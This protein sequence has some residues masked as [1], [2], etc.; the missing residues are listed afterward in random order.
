MQADQ[1][2]ALDQAMLGVHADLAAMFAI[3][4][5]ADEDRFGSLTGQ[6]ARVLE[7]LEPGPADQ[8]EVAVYLATLIRWL[9]TDPWPQDARFSGQPLTP[10]RIERKLRIA[11]SSNR[12]IDDRDADDLGSRCVRLVV[13]GGPGSGKTWL[14]RRTARLCA[15]AALEAL[16]GGAG[17]EEVE[18]PLYT[19]CARLAAA[20]PGDNI[21]SAVVSTALG[22]LPDLGGSRVSDALRKLFEERHAATLLVADSLD[23]AHGA[24]DRIRQADS[25]PAVWRI[26]LTSRPASWNR[27]LN[28]PDDDQA[29]LVGV[30]QP[31]RY[32]VDVEPFITSWF[33]GQPAS[34]AVLADQLRNRPGLQQAATVPLVLTFYC[35]IGGDAPL[36]DRRADLYAKV[37]RRM[38]TGRWRGGG[39][40]DPN[41]EA[42]L[43]VLRD[44]AW[45][46]AA[47]NR[48]S[49]VGAWEDEFP[50]RRPRVSQDDRDA[51]GHVAAP[52]GPADADTGRTWRRFVHRSV[53]E[54]LVAEDVAALPVDKAA[55]ALLPHLWY[56]PDWEYSA[57]AAI[58]MHPEHDQLLRNLICLA[59]RSDKMPAD[60]SVIDSGREFRS[61]LARVAA[62]SSEAD[63]APEIAGV[64]AGARLGLARS[65]WTNDLSAA[66]HWET[67][68]RPIRET[69]LGLLTNA[70]GEKAAHLADNILQLDPTLE[71][72]TR[73]RTA[74]MQMMASPIHE[75]VAARLVP[76]V[77]RLAVTA[78]EKRQASIALLELL[79]TIAY[80]GPATARVVDGVVK[81]VATAADKRQ[82]RTAL[83]GV[84]ADQNSGPAARPLVD[85]LVKLD[86]TTEDKRQARSAL[87]ELLA[88]DSTGLRVEALVDSLLQLD[89]AVEDKRRAMEILL[90]IL[91]GQ[92]DGRFA[93]SIVEGM[94]KLAATTEDKRQARAALSKLLADGR[95]HVLAVAVLVDGIVKL[96][97]TAEDEREARA[98]LLELL[99]TGRY[100][101]PVT[102]RPAPGAPNLGAIAYDKRQAYDRR[103]IRLIAA[104]LAE[105]VALLNPTVDEKRQARMALLELLANQTDG[106]VAPLLVESMTHLDPAAGDI[107]WAWTVLLEHLADETG[108]RAT[109]Q[110]AEGL[111]KF[112]TSAED[113]RQAREALLGLLADEDDS[114]MAMDLAQGVAQLDPTTEDKRRTQNV[115]AS[116]LAD[117]PDHWMA[118]RLVDAVV[119]LA[120]S[121]E[122]RRHARETLSGLLAASSRGEVAAELAQGVAHFNPTAEDKRQAREALLRLLADE[123]DGEVAAELVERVAQLDPTTEDKR[124]GRAA[125]LGLLPRQADRELAFYL[126]EQLALLEVTVDDLSAWHAW[127][128]VTTVLLSAVRRN[129][130]P[131]D[132]LK[133]LPS[134]AGLSGS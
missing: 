128:L 114:E 88:R 53:R 79:A 39:D 98:A 82:A 87:V 115:L 37:I 92:A 78:E 69:L 134:L 19:T 117:A 10:A 17:L 51:L 30:L 95:Y 75:P 48:I 1:A 119:E 65:G 129:S 121:A 89:P 23:E 49:G 11:S 84:L 33:T 50:T 80:H 34:G 59:A 67:S 72:R 16:A 60:L 44:W 26:V 71:D 20:P 101:V 93:D 90:G 131:P 29:R 5:M 64:I 21:R 113:K 52:V 120:G 122:D 73:A 2:S 58:A 102:A 68:N 63:W 106:S 83:L 86:P 124:R 4:D 28:I 62:E 61:L 56:D 96:T 130:T 99:A 107:R 54:H 85:G 35:I 8:G 47:N 108:H 18:L 6:L 104:H 133:A 55:E 94:L 97:A 12:D 109:R 132:W 32:P 123:N 36:P 15:E 14:A 7:R 40:R 118:A 127:P 57:P 81:V 66:A 105:G 41:P 38:L 70:T 100:L 9:N 24:D 46:G 43:E 3:R 74:L 42:C 22:H 125:L 27:Q 31:L 116:L 110:L 45:S 126:E 112:A 77:I 13:L 111:V 91:A 25:L 103:V 76:R